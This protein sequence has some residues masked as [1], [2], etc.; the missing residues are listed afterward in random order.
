[1][2]DRAGLLGGHGREKHGRERTRKGQWKRFQEADRIGAE[3][4]VPLCGPGE[5]CKLSK[6]QFPHL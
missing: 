2:A 3:L 5:V 1:M 4:S 6:P